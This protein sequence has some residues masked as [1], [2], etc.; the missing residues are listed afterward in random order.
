MAVDNTTVTKMPSVPTQSR[1]IAVPASQAM[2]EMAPSAKVGL[3]P[4]GAP[5][6]A[7]LPE[8]VMFMSRI[9]A[10]TMGAEHSWF[11][12]LVYL[13]ARVLCIGKKKS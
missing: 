7:I 10:V 4:C 2:W 3:L 1:D 11:L 12:S 6:P 5:P 13:L 8:L 9:P